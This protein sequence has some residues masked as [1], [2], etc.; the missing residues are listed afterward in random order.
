MRQILIEASF[1]S[2]TLFAIL[3][4]LTLDAAKTMHAGDMA[5]GEWLGLNGIKI[6]LGMASLVTG[7]VYSETSFVSKVVGEESVVGRILQDDLIRR[8]WCLLLGQLWFFI[9]LEAWFTNAYQFIS[10]SH[11]SSSLL[12]A[13]SSC[14]ALCLIAAFTP[15]QSVICSDNAPD[16]YGSPFSLL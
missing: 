10:N 12:A 3:F 11:L 5:W 9:S 16:F 2:L 1:T 15:S 6:N 4:I 13:S 7:L 14:T 8:Y